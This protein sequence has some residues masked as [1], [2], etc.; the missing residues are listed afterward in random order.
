MKKLDYRG[1]PLFWFT[2]LVISLSLPYIAAG[3]DRPALRFLEDSQLTWEDERL[4]GELKNVPVKSL[5][6]KLSEEKNFQLVIIGDLNEQVDVSFDK[7]TLEQCIKRVMRL[8][9]LSYLMVV[10]GQG[11]SDAEP[12]YRIKKL[13]ICQK[14]KSSPPPRA[15]RRAPRRYEKKTEPVVKNRSLD[16]EE[17]E[18]LIRHGPSR[19]TR[20]RHSVVSRES[21]PDLEGSPEDIT[22]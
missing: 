21:K 15:S 13:I 4:T 10:E 9:D 17:A 20:E 6:K 5:L 3:Q 8:S 18:F 1:W 16:E 11:S 19:D 7:L 12:P 14:G 2:I 22:K